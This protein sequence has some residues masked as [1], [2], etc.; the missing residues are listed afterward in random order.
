MF[1]VP[2]ASQVNYQHIFVDS[3]SDRNEGRKRNKTEHNGAD[4]TTVKQQRR[5]YSGTSTMPDKLER[6]SGLQNLPRNP[7]PLWS[8]L[9]ISFQNRYKFLKMKILFFEHKTIKKLI[10]ASGFLT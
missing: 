4:T 10:F 9:S 1:F 8:F 3:I 5:M 7:S 2:V 6:V